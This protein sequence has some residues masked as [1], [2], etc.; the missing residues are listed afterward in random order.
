M[1]RCVAV[2][3]YIGSLCRNRAA[4]ADLRVATVKWG[5]SAFNLGVKSAQKIMA[6]ADAQCCSPKR[7]VLQASQ[8]GEALFAD[9]WQ[10]VTSR[11]GADLVIPEHIVL[12]NGPPGSGKAANMPVLQGALG[13][14][15]NVEMSA[16][17]RS[18]PQA[19]SAQAVMD[20]GS[21][22]PDAR[23]CI[24]LLH[25]LLNPATTDRAGVIVD[26][27]P[28]TGL[29]VRGDGLCIVSCLNCVKPA[30]CARCRACGK[31]CWAPGLSAD[32]ISACAG[33]FHRC[34]AASPGCLATTASPTLH[35]SA[36]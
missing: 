31:T 11:Y 20:N 5:C 23:P 18:D 28:R 27:F 21:L 12:L 6:H 9:G 13:I 15:H 29:Q 34:N 3:L 17:L 8:S 36:T 24:A 26:G 22:V 2:S 7:T 25:G 14:R 35:S 16:L 32:C 4:H 30:Y 1:Y 19:T 10:E 33:R